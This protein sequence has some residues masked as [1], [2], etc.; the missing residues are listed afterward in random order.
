M[1]ARRE[2]RPPESEII[3]AFVDE[4]GRPVPVLPAV[5]EGIQKT[6][7]GPRIWISH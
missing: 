5:G 2:A 7:P 4:D 1:P 6:I 3:T